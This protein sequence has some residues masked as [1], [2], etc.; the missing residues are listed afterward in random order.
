MRIRKLR[1]V[2]LLIFLFGV[3]GPLGVGISLTGMF[4]MV[5][6]VSNRKRITSINSELERRGIDP[7]NESAVHPLLR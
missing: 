2:F 1:S 7:F 5:I 6:G 3:S 4:G